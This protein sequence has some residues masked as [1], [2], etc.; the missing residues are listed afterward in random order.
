[1]TTAQQASALLDGGTVVGPDGEIGKVG[2]VFLDDETGKP[3][4]VTVKTG[5]F[6]S[7]ESF[8]PL[9]GAQMSGSE[10]RVSFDKSKVK[11]APNFDVDEHLSVN[12]EEALYSYYGLGSATTTTTTTETAAAAPKTAVSTDGT[13]TRSEEQLHV[14]TQQVQTGKARLRKFVVTEQ[15]TVNVPVSHEEVRVVREPLQPGEAVDGSTIGEDS[16]EVA[17]TAERAVV[18]K[19]VVGVERIR[20]DKN[21]VTEQQAVTEEVR[22]EQIEMVS[23]EPQATTVPKQPRR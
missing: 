10:V 23:D 19:E 16:I 5:F 3:N 18:N 7:N 20:L 9:E 4:W 12:D 11:G 6:G 17:L 13:M 21:V 14:G 8:I 15:Q 2:Q 1:M 22:K